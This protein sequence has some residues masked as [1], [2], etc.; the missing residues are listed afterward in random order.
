MAPVGTAELDQRQLSESFSIL[1]FAHAMVYSEAQIFVCCLRYCPRMG[2]M[3]INVFIC[4]AD[5]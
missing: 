5:I 4:K 1:P 2:W 3:P